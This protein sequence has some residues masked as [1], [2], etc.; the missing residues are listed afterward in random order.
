MP[1]AVSPIHNLLAHQRQAME[2]GSMQALGVSVGGPLLQVRKR[3]TIAQV[4]AGATIVPSQGTGLKLRMV[5]YEVIAVGGLA[6]GATT[7]DILGTISGVS[8]KLGAIA[9]AGLTQSTVN[10]PGAANNTVLADG[11]SYVPLDANTAITIGKTGATLTGP[12][13]I[14]VIL[15]FAADKV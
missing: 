5:D 4:N 9:V 8:S 13:N 7:V 3:F 2:S 14:D 10:R 6:A 1:A 12:T 15:K 11:G